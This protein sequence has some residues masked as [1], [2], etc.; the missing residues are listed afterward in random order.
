M[1]KIQTKIL[2]PLSIGLAIL[3]LITVLPY[4]GAQEA[5]ILGYKS[6]CPF[7]PFSTII[8]IYTALTLY[9]YQSNQNR[10]EKTP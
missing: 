9:R 3:A 10:K 4:G 7:S 8:I 5:S 2:K 1:K 6:L